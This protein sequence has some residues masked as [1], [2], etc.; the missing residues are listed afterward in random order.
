[1]KII[2]D[3][4]GIEFERR[5]AEYNRSKKL[6][7]KNYHN[8]S[9]ASKHG[10]SNLPKEM[11]GDTTFLKKGSE[12]DEFT[13]FRYHLRK[14]RNRK[15]DCDLTLEYLKEVWDKQEGKCVYTNL[16]MINKTNQKSPYTAS[17]DRINSEFGYIKRNVQFVCYSINLAKCDFTDEETKQ[18]LK[19]IAHL[20]S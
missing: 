20:P 1:M 2:C 6:G 8:Q 17:L 16:L 11:L 4:C 15:K 3:G 19:S 5:T 12:Q 10:V 13:P 18:F 7:R 14:A 9:C